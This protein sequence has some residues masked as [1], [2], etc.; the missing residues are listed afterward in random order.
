MLG[1]RAGNM[2]ENVVERPTI[3][4]VA[5]LAA[6]SVGTASK[7]LNGRGSMRP[8]TRQR[9]REAAERLGFQANVAARSLQGGRTYTVGMITTDS[10]GRFS[11]PVLLGSEDSLGAGRM[12]VFL[13]DARDDP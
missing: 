5:A 4:D 7:A 3:G 10:I 2:E 13:C 9:V 6:V 12:S 1:T 11:I 8:E